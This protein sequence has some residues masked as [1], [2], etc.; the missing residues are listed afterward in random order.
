M[1][2][3]Y[4]CFYRDEGTQTVVEQRFRDGPAE[5]PR[6][7]V[8]HPPRDWETVVGS[9]EDPDAGD[10]AEEAGDDPDDRRAHHPEEASGVLDPRSFR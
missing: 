3:N 2:I 10:G 7:A 9:K 1:R 4:S 5:R 6:S 8:S